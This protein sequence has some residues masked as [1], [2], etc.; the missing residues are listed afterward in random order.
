[1]TTR[2]MTALDSPEAP[3]AAR[4]LAGACLGFVVSTAGLIGLMLLVGSL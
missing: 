4:S 2:P 1:M 3:G